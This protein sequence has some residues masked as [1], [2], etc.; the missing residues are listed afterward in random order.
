MKAMGR[1][2][3]ARETRLRTLYR[4]RRLLGRLGWSTGWPA[5]CRM[6]PESPVMLVQQSLRALKARRRERI[7]REQ[8]R[9]RTTLHVLA[10]GAV[11]GQDAFQK[12]RIHADL[13]RDRAT[14][15]IEAVSAGS[16]GNA[17]DSV[18]MLEG[19]RE[20]GWLPLVW[21]TDNG[22]QYRSEEVREW[23]VSNMVVDLPS[24][25]HTPQHNGATERAVR[26]L[27]G[28]A[29]LDGCDGPASACSELARSASALNS[30]MPRQSRGWLTAD[31]LDSAI[32]AWYLSVRRE[33]F[34]SA[35]VEGRRAA[36]AGLKPREGRKAEREVVFQCLERFGLA[37]RKTGDAK[38][39]P[40][41][42]EIDL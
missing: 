15:R 40:R 14:M 5:M 18:S 29:G 3:H 16:P 25:P 24:L 20:S 42:P 13:V 26:E 32:P 36:S 38:S 22:S 7:R 2:P 30:L 41:K 1:P 31:Q 23:L 10:R 4:V 27:K 39:G 19:L 17:A 35:V 6:L 8:A 28:V 33:D 21:Q 11:M 34:F 12:G 37:V 9:R